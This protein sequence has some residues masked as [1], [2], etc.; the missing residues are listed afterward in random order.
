MAFEKNHLRYDFPVEA[1]KTMSKI[2]YSCQKGHSE[3]KIPTFMIQK[4]RTF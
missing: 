1:F 3:V 4:D 2:V